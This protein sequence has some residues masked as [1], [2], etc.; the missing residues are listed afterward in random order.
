MASSGPNDPK[1]KEKE[2]KMTSTVAMGMKMSRV[3]TQCWKD[4]VAKERQIK[5]EWGKVYDPQHLQRED[6]I[7]H[8]VMEKEKR[9]KEA[10]PPPERALLYDGVSKDG[11]GRAAYLKAR[12]KKNPQEKQPFPL[13]SSQVVGWSALEIPPLRSPIIDLYKPVTA[14]TRKG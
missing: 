4:Q 12:L 1:M 7:I 2:A 9:K 11:K 5:E 10:P 14:V 6:E 3:A 8:E 13:A